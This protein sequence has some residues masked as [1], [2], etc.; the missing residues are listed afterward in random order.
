MLLMSSKLQ[1]WL[2][3]I[4]AGW[5]YHHLPSDPAGSSHF[6]EDDCVRAENKKQKKMF[7]FCHRS[8]ENKQTGKAVV[9]FHHV[10]IITKSG[11]GGGEAADPVCSSL[12]GFPFFSPSSHMEYVNKHR[13]QNTTMSP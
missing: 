1:R 10:I 6:L 3:G 7:M 9:T 2:T 13:V 5:T 8:I 11:F 12:A 4:P